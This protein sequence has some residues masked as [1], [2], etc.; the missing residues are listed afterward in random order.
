MPP[1]PALGR[2]LS[3]LLS[4]GKGSTTVHELPVDQITPNRA[5]PRKR[6]NP[7]TLAELAATIKAKGVAQPILVRR[8][9][10]RYELIAGERRWRAARLAGLRTIPAILREATDRESLELALVE[11]LQREDLNP[12]DEALS[13]QVLLKEMT[14]EELARRVGRDRTTVANTLRLLKLP[15]EV[16]DA[17]ADGRLTAGHARAIL[18]LDAPAAQVALFRRILR[19]G[20]SV[21]AA[22]AAAQRLARPGAVR[23]RPGALANDEEL[24]RALGTKVRIRRAG[25][26]GTIVIEFYSAEELERL[27]AL[28]GRLGR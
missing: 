21:R 19:A 23:A 15:R 22:E 14:Q 5:Q 16:Q 11:N 2:G 6:F 3:T 9:G 17:V 18:Q 27:V 13:F 7:A 28:L 10:D 24:S 8:A 4:A 12:L 25:K 20:L 1:R 26:R